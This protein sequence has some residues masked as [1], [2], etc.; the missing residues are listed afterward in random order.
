M[1]VKCIKSRFP[2]L[3]VVDEIYD[4]ETLISRTNDI[5]YI[6]DEDGDPWFFIAILM[7]ADS[8][9]ALAVMV[10]QLRYL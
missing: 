4:I 10:C 1:F 9:M 8:L 6:Y 7:V 3:F 5:Q 2:D